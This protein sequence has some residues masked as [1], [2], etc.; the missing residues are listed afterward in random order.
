MR[1]FYLFIFLVFA[2]SGFSQQDAWVYFNAKPNAQFYLDSPLTMLSQ[3]A[4]DRRTTQNI[5]LDFKDI[6]V[7]A[8]FVTQVTGSAGISVMARSKW[9]NAIHVRGSQAAINALA[10][11]SFISKIDFADKTLN[12][13]GRLSKPF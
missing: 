2:I 13:V 5:A 6:P 9:L 10:T 7:E 11:F 1:K 12:Q 3:R 8:S 4:L